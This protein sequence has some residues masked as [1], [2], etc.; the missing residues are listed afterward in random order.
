MS[1]LYR[2][3]IFS[4]TLSRA[5]CVFFFFL[6]S[7]CDM[8]RPKKGHFIDLTGEVDN[9]PGPSSRHPGPSSRRPAA[10]DESLGVAAAAPKPKGR[11][12]K[13]GEEGAPGKKAST[14]QKPEK[15]IDASGKTVR[16]ASTPSIKV[17][18]RIARAMPGELALGEPWTR[19]C[20]QSQDTFFST[21]D[22]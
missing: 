1:L 16:Y 6:F 4:S 2:V 9:E 11:K 22:L 13:A 3:D 14:K 17:Q 19:G 20:A 7:K 10:A 21:M 5:L 12:R 15:R 8:P 18:E